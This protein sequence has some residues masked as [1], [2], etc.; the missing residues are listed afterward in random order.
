MNRRNTLL[1]EM[2]EATRLVRAGALNDAM[3]VIRQGLRGRAPPA[4][5]TN[6]RDVTPEVGRFTSHSFSN[7][8]GTRE[9]KLYVPSGYHGQPMPL[10]VMLHGCTQNPD[11][12]A[13][14]TRMNEL[15][16]ELGFLVAYPAQ[17]GAASANRCWNWFKRSEQRHGEGE[18]SLI[19]GIA[20]KVMADHALDNRQVYLAGLSSG[21]AMAAILGATYP[22]LFAAV[23]VHS[24][25]PFGSAHDLPSALAAMR[26]GNAGPAVPG[27][28]TIVFHGDA[29]SLV[30]PRNSDELVAQWLAGQ[31]G[32]IM[33]VESG[34]KA[35]GRGYTR[36]VLRDAAG[37]PVLEHWLVHGAGH[38]WSGGSA[39]GS[40]TDPRGPDA[41]SEMVRFFLAHPRFAEI[42]GRA[43]AA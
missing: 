41:S 19:A 33:T 24:G 10:V 34:P 22:E 17:S 13:A 16:E 27:V 8:A 2:T 3:A 12:F 15:A 21:G 36:R 37:H 42:T 29:D 28:P 25:L 35:H 38:A 30:H 7:P 31:P 32:S 14:G 11:D 1:P 40:H 20:R 18:P 26:N 6:V 23:G 39:A 43:R 4:P 5:G 9:Y